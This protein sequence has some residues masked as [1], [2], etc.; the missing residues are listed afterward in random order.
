MKK[1][2]LL[3]LCLASTVSFAKVYECEFKDDKDRQ[4]YLE[5]N[6]RKRSASVVL[7]SESY[8]HKQR[9]CKIVKN[10]VGTTINCDKGKKDLMILLQRD[11]A[12]VTGGI[13]SDHL[14]LFADISC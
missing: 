1:L 3:T 7:K 6:L 10:N 2:L 9:N 4:G 12:P 14:D 13:M 11:R 8:S 5:V